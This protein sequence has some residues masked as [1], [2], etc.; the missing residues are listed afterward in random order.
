MKTGGLQTKCTLNVAMPLNGVNNL[1]VVFGID[2]K[3]AGVPAM[4]FSTPLNYFDV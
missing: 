3:F 2:D 4:F 1:F